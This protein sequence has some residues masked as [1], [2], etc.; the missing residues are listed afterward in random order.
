[1]SS[2][3]LQHRVAD[4]RITLSMLAAMIAASLCLL[5]VPAQ[6]QRIEQLFATGNAA[7]F[8]GEFKTAAARYQQLVDAGVRD[9]DVFFNLGVAQARLGA[10]GRAVWYFQRAQELSPDDPE[11]STALATA[12]AALGKRRAEAQG[13]ATI[14]TRPPLRQALVQPYRENTLAVLVL[15]LEALFFGLLMARSVL[16]SETLRAGAA[17]LAALSF[18][19]LGAA[20]SGLAVKRGLFDDGQPAVV[21]RDG[22]ELREGPDSHARSRGLAHEGQSARVLRRDA[23]FVRVR[24][25][26]G[27]EGW[28]RGSDLGLL[29]QD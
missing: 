21:L 29:A 8:Q 26:G 20:A 16:R 4:A 3:R 19:G 9:P 7:Y 13:E 27:A 17:M 11:L 24:L 23:A 25:A 28:L 6:A 1:M 5:A 12:R 2:R 10:L 15:V 22:A 18:L 14:E